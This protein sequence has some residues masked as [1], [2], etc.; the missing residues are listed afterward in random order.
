MVLKLSRA[1][2]RLGRQ[3]KRGI[4]SVRKR[5]IK[6]IRRSGRRLFEGAKK[7]GKKKLQDIIRDPTKIADLPGDIAK[8]G[9]NLLVGE[10]KKAAEEILGDA[11]KEGSKRA[12]D[13]AESRAIKAGVPAS[14]AKETRRRLE[15]LARK[16]AK[17][18]IKEK[19]GIE[20]KGDNPGNPPARSNRGPDIPR[21][22]KPAVQPPGGDVRR[23]L[24]ARGMS[25][26]E[27]SRVMK[28]MK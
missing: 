5:G 6:Q 17:E 28:R 19:T 8:E 13:A 3:I 20:V 25:E 22:F 11:L 16:K 1:F 2:S 26:E 4:K 23:L 14:V 24:K 27:I 12:F 7:F 21:P 10:A 18:K 15:A 9:R